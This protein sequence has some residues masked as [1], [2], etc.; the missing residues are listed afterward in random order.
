MPKS[1]HKDYTPNDF[2]LHLHLLAISDNLLITQKITKYKNT[3]L[4]LTYK[5][6]LIKIIFINQN[7]LYMVKSINVSHKCLTSTDLALL[8][9]VYQ[10]VQELDFRFK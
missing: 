10:T 8:N 5:N 9:L 7:D 4:I 6:S 2:A 1:S 3:C